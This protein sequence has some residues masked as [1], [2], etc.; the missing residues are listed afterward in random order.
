MGASSEGGRSE[1]YP[2]DHP[3]VGERM[4]VKLTKG[5]EDKVVIR[6]SGRE[7]RKWEKVNSIDCSFI[8]W[9]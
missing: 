6:I 1:A 7:S 8:S 9:L 2:I 5:R 4:K 3:C